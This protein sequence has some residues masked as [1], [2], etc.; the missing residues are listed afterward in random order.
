MEAFSVFGLTA[1]QTEILYELERR[2]VQKDIRSE[3]KMSKSDNKSEWLSE[4]VQSIDG[5]FRDTLKIKDT[6]IF[7]KCSEQQ[8]LTRMSAEKQNNVWKYMILL[9]CVLFSAYFPFRKE[10]AKKYKGLKLLKGP[11]QE[12]LEQIATDFLGVD[13]KYIDLFEK[14]F[15]K[16][17]KRMSKYWWKVGGFALGMMAVALIAIFTFQYEILGLFAAEGTSGAALISSGLAALGGGAI[18][19]GGGGMAAGTA[20]F[21]GGG[22]L[23]GAAVGMPSGFVIATATNSKLFLSQAAK[24]E[25]VMKEIV[26]AIQKD[27]ACFQKILLNLMK[28]MAELSAEVQRLKMRDEKNKKTISEMQKSIGYLESVIGTARK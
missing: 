4:W 13:P 27:T 22:L 14:R 9:E 26:L 5:Y 24:M 7:N 10:D 12:M 28:E 20:V 16:S 19:A 25:V 17:F 3:E 11:R 23:M 15:E 2:L 1:T 21:V 6:S 18:A 8:L